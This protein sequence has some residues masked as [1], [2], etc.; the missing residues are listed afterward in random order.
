MPPFGFSRSNLVRPQ[1]GRYVAGVC[2]AIG[3]A[4]NTDPTL[5]RVIFAV[6]TLAGGVSIVAYLLGWLLLPA[7]GDTGSPLEALLGRGRST[8]S[9]PVAIVIG[10][11]AVLAFLLVM[12]RNVGAAAVGLAVVIGV[13]ALLVRGQGNLPPGP[14]P[15]Q[16]GGPLGGG[17]PWMPPMPPTPPGP[18]VPGPAAA[19]P[20]P[21]SVPPFQSAGPSYTGRGG[22]SVGK[23]PGVHPAWL[24]HQTAVTQPVPAATPATPAPARP[25]VPPAPLV[26][27]LPPLP[28]L[29]PT[30]YRPPFAPHGP[31]SGSSP[32]AASLGYPA[33][34]PASPYP[35]LAPQP[36][37]PP[38]PPKPRSR[39]GRVIFSLICLSLGVLAAL[40][41]TTFDFLVSTYFAVPLA[42]V[43]LGLIVG[44]WFGRA[45]LMILLGVVLSLALAISTA[46]TMDGPSTK[47]VENININ[48]MSVT[49]LDS[50]YRTDFGNIH[51]DLRQVDFT[52][53]DVNISFRVG[54][55]GNMQIILP[56]NVDVS[57]DV[58]VEG[59][60][61]RVLGR[62]C[63]GFNQTNE[64]TD[65]GTDGAG[66][67]KL[68]LDLDLRY[69][70]LE[71]T[72]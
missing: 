24:Q 7:E 4:T 3:R 63:G 45:R 48:P 65:L 64:F 46:S 56:K 30:G 16:P 58:R 54:Y 18:F 60:D 61:C 23:T 12:S 55:G 47:D 53:Q 6:L 13:V 22:G 26:P 21:P 15:D 42:I 71:V 10:V 17:R 43:A 33:G 9:A 69:G 36:P 44:A 72:R 49:E 52:G 11:G 31:F 29:P 2:A 50:D 8:T 25:S 34:A 5:W 70:N 32:Y 19:A 62:E 27:P 66:G 20:F 28:P 41:V 38:K 1:H 67:G 40:E 59:G 68:H 35:G 39:L 51:A 37:K 14:Q 57:V